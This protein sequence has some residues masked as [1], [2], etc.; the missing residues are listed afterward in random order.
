MVFGQQT[1]PHQHEHAFNTSRTILGIAQMYN[2]TTNT[3]DG[4]I[5]FQQLE[6]TVL[7]SKSTIVLVTGSI[8]GEYSVGEHGFHILQVKIKW[9]NLKEI[10]RN[11]I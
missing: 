5:E 2:P 4:Y 10:E 9:G 7:G 1:T 11:L 3:F 6:G 8:Q